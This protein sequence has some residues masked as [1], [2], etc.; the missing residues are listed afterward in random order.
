MT[1]DIRL[2]E[3]IYDGAR[4]R[5][6]R[7]WDDGANRPVILKQLRALHP[8]AAEVARLARELSITR[9]A[10]NEGVAAAHALIEEQ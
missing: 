1:T 4:F 6:S 3:R 10:E 5:V 7:G 2:N 9:F 8:T